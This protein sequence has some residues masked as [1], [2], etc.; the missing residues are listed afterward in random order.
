MVNQIER[1]DELGII[2]FK[3]ETQYEFL[4]RGNTVL[5]VSEPYKQ[6][7]KTLFGDVYTPYRV[8]D[9]IE[10][11][12]DTNLEWL[13]IRYVKERPTKVLPLVRFLKKRLERIVEKR[14]STFMYTKK[15]LRKLEELK[16]FRYAKIGLIKTKEPK[17]AG[18]SGYKRVLGKIHMP[19]LEIHE[20]D[21]D[22]I[23]HEIIETVRNG[24]PTFRFL[25]RFRNNLM[26]V[27]KTEALE[28]VISEYLCY[29]L[30]VNEATDTLRQYARLWHCPSRVIYSRLRLKQFLESFQNIQDYFDNGE[31][32]ILRLTISEI[33]KLGKAIRE[34]DIENFMQ[35]Q[36]GLKWKIIRSNTQVKK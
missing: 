27:L 6:L 36:N 8:F 10:Y 24:Q 19:Y 4:K 5:K 13:P 34:R 26:L 28:Q 21:E 18:T 29:K 33:L 9:Y 1:L 20:K 25:D 7:L 35:T 17:T 15:E 3:N 32:I 11:L 2:P 23:V 14:W 22:T 12:T 30:D 31:Y 16:P